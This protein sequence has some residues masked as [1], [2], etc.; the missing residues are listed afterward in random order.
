MQDEE[1]HTRQRT[2]GK[3]DITGQRETPREVVSMREERR[4]LALGR[5]GRRRARMEAVS[6]RKD[7]NKK[8]IDVTVH[9][10]STAD[11]DF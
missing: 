7:V 10:I 9:K 11:P 6:A 3:T 5:K 1:H 4:T 8:A 2:R